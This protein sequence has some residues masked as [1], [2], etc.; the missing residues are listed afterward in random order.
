MILFMEIIWAKFDFWRRKKP[1]RG[2]FFLAVDVLLPVAVL[3]H[4]GCVANV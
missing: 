3:S 1:F 4:E 2:G